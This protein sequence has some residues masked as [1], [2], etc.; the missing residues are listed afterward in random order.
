MKKIKVIAVV[1]PTASGK[2]KYSIELAKR[3]GGEIISSDSR[4][5]YKGM[6]IGTA[7]P[8]TS[9][10]DGI[11][12][13]MIDIVEPDF[14]YS[15]ALYQTEASKIIQA[16][17]SRGKIPI[18]VGGTGL[19]VD[20]LLK[21]FSLP[22]IEPDY[23]LRDELSK[24]S[25][26]ELADILKKY[27]SNA[28]N[29]IADNDKKKIIRAIEIVKTTNKPLNESRT[30]NDELYD[31]E[32]IGRNLERNELYSKIETRVDEMMDNGLIDETKKL[33]SKYGRIRNITDTIG[34]REIC[35]YLNNELSLEDAVSLL[36]Q[37]TRHYAKR[38]MTWFRK[39]PNISW[40]VYPETLKK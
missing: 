22:R 1:G 29:T 14:D 32:W 39:N 31:V 19:Y 2:T 4:L 13:H 12:H 21:N 17:S 24:L 18:V 16:V 36:K 38:Q 34:Y 6:D 5:V 33:L 8:T 30:V 23:K 37:N 11:P 10:M 7:K 20:I 9:E 28:L 3:V 35:M 15:A 27:D 25:Y 40:N 26:E